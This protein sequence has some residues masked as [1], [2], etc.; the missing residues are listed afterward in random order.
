ME[1]PDYTITNRDQ[2]HDNRVGE[3]DVRIGSSSVEP[4][5]GS[6]TRERASRSIQAS[7][8]TKVHRCHETEKGESPS[9]P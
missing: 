1:I 6:R 9:M 5:M 7:W 2:A 3:A 4:E 8:G